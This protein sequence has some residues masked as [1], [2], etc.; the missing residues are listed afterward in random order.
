MALDQ[1]LGQ[2]STYLSYVTMLADVTV[3][4]ELKLKVAQELSEN[5]EVQI[6]TRILRTCQNIFIIFSAKYFFLNCFI[7]KRQM[8][9][10]IN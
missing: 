1:Q 9:N 10:S 4:D 7:E 2:I 3:K 6:I 5:F 8:S